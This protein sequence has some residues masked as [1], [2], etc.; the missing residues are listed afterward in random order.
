[1]SDPQMQLDT[2]SLEVAS[3]ALTTVQAMAGE[4]RASMQAHEEHDDDR[5]KL[6]A[7]KVSAGFNGIYNRIW[8]A[9]LALIAGMG[10]VILF[11]ADK[12]TG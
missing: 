2:R 3:A 8:M 10:A 11:L 5:F 7:D 12:V 6:I 4:F 1:M 9:V